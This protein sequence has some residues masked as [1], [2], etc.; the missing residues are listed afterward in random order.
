MFFMNRKNANIAIL[1]VIIIIAIFVT[2]GFFGIGGFRL[3]QP[4]E[5]STQSIL[6]EVQT[7]GT[8][9]DLRIEDMVEGSGDAVVAGDTLTVHYVGVLPDGTVFDS[10]V[11]KNTPF[12]FTIGAG[13]VIQGW[14][15]GLLGMKKGGQRLLVIP[16]SLGYGA[17]GIGQ[18]P[19]NATLIFQVE[20]LEKTSAGSAQ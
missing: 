7:T 17:T 6:D 13:T 15:R 4:A 14:E 10:S 9:A 20:L 11:E 18:I 2:L 19:P 16:P 12:T 8:V 5:T 3:G 1:L